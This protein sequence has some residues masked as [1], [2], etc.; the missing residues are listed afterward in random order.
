M[1]Q[2]NV[3]VHFR[4]FCCILRYGKKLEP[5]KGIKDSRKKVIIMQ[6][7]FVGGNQFQNQMWIVSSFFRKYSFTRLVSGDQPAVI[8]DSRSSSGLVR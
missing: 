1:R 3:I 7:C 6:Q 4:V 2:I 5:I 8:S